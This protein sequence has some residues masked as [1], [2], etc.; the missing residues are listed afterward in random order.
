M[1]CRVSQQRSGAHGAHL[2]LGGLL[3]RS[4]GLLG[5]DLR[6]RQGRLRARKRPERGGRVLPGHPA[7]A[8]YT[9]YGPKPDLRQLG[10]PR[11]A[12]DRCS[13]R[14]ALPA[15]GRV[16]CAGL[17][18]AGAPC[19]VIMHIQLARATPSNRLQ[20]GARPRPR[21]CWRYCRVRWRHC[22]T[23]STSAWHSLLAELRAS[24]CTSASALWLV[25][26]TAL[27]EACPSCAGA[28]RIHQTDRV[29]TRPRAAPAPQRAARAPQQPARAPPP[30]ARAQAP[31]RRRR[32][33]RQP[34]AC[35]AMPLA[36]PTERA[37][38]PPRRPPRR[39]P[40]HPLTCAA[41]W[42][43]VPALAGLGPRAEGLWWGCILKHRAWRALAD[44]RL[45]S[46]R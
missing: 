31:A 24:V 3:R 10:L 1:A 42:A 33:P 22:F 21:L 7:R 36:S 14:Q 27:Q 9:P 2:E 32:R 5:S 11:G 45:H 46:Y 15:Q 28:H 19:V 40:A 37:S 44:G 16:V 41:A 6:R 30:V 13:V 18:P 25:H 34:P 23:N 12:D 17:E 20:T 39:R 26:F 43:R 38:S 35:C 8:G 4:A 29:R